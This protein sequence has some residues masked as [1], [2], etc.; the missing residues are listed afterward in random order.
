M[1][2]TRI[3]PRWRV[4]APLNSLFRCSDFGLME[5]ANFLEWFE[6]KFLLHTAKLRETAPVIL[7]IDGHFSHIALD[8]VLVAHENRVILYNLAPNTTHA[9][10]PS[11]I[12]V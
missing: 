5:R 10:Q 8:L 3:D 12:A 1:G 4:G 2:L 11:L 6:K 9:L 7:F